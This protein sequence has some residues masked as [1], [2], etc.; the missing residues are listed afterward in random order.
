MLQKGDGYKKNMEK[1]AE[2]DIDR[3]VVN[4]WI[5]GRRQP[6]MA[7]LQKI[8]EILGFDALIFYATDEKIDLLPEQQ[9]VCEL[10]KRNRNK[11]VLNAAKEILKV[12]IIE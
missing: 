12:G 5:N 9:E 11:Q 7:S 10:A 2:H 1:L 3:N 6:Q 4:S 8:A